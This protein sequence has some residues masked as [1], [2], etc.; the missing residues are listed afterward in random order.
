VKVSRLWPVVRVLVLPI[1][2]IVIWQAFHSFGVVDRSLVPT[3]KET[4]LRA[5]HFFT[6]GNI[7][8]DL[9]ETAA[10]MA[11]GL[12]LAILV[13]VPL[14]MFIGAFKPVY[15]VT[16]PAIDFVRSTPVTILYPVIVLILGVTH[17]AKIAMVFIACIFV[18]ALN[19]AYGVMRASETRKQMAR[20]YG[21]SRS[22]LFR[23]VLFFDSLP[24]TM[25]GLRISLSFALVVEVLC[26]LFMGSKYGLGQR[27]SEAY[28]TYAIADLYALILIVGTFGFVLNRAFVVIEKKVVPWSEM[29]QR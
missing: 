19:T 10:R 12:G 18:I 8:R 21:A 27:V 14:G 11:A 28:T 25:V 17:L 6:S 4:F 26:E 29:E 1:M 15:E 2:L 22:Q 13:G 5:A 23:W 16:L 20:V 3:P 7:L 9:W 24:Q